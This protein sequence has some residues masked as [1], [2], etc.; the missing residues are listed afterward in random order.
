MPTRIRGSLRLLLL[1]Q[2]LLALVV[3]SILWLAN[4]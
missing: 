2:V 4:R 1:V 3:A